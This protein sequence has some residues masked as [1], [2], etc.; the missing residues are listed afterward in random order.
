MTTLND[1]QNTWLTNVGQS[2]GSLNDK[3][4]AYLGG[5]GFTGSLNDRF[6]AFL[7]GSGSINY[8]WMT[9]LAAK[10]YTTGSLNDRML[11]YFAT[12]PTAYDMIAWTHFLYAG[13]SGWAHP[14]D[15]DPVDS[16]RN[17]TGGGD[18]AS[19]GANRP[20]YRASVAAYNN[21]PA[22][23]FASASSQRLDFDVVNLG[24][25]FSLVV[26]GN[27]NGSGTAAE[28]LMGSG[29]NSANGIGD[30]AGNAWTLQFG[31]GLNGGAC[32]ANPH[33]F[34]G[35]ANGASSVVAVDGTV[36]ATGNAST[37]T[38][39]RLTIGA[40]ANATPVFANFLNG[41]IVVAGVAIGDVSTQAG[42]AKFKAWVT[43]EYG[44]TV[45]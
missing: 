36:I 34:R 31:A 32:D 24:Q 44:I 2:T 6:A 10:G 43:L 5:R 3:W 9:Y 26:I 8:R 28:R 21:K 20:T 29:G 13:D 15:G 19:T 25:P 41:R 39:T 33:L 38:L 27:T 17:M 22:V 12:A 18:P 42:W 37:N 4:Y 7:G 35:Y 11:A 16:W 1:L 14:A 45:A 40:G 23:E 30:T